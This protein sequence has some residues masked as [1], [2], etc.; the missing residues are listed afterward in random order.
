MEFPGRAK[1][2]SGRQVIRSPYRS[3][4]VPLMND[5]R[6]GF[7]VVGFLLLSS[8]ASTAL[9]QGAAPA[10]G[11]NV[12]EIKLAPCPGMPTCTTGSVQA[13]DP[14]K[15]SSIILARMTSG[16]VFPWHWHTPG[17]HI[18][19]VSGTARV[20]MKDARPLTLRS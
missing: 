10:P 16:C 1:R 3:G 6:H 7:A 20:E 12:S 14:A 8:V 11:H 19:M 5:L 4:E 18:M 2:L 17:E 9:A 13:G 15:G